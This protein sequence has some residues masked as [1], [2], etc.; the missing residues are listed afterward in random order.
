MRGSSAWPL[1]GL[2]EA[3]PI[4]RQL[5]GEVKGDREGKEEE[6]GKVGSI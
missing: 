3:A 4:E 1:R 2:V 6:E 5:A